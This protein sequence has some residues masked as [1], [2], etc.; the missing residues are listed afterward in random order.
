MNVEIDDNSEN[1]NLSNKNNLDKYDKNII[2]ARGANKSNMPSP[3]KHRSHRKKTYGEEFI[4]NK[5]TPIF[6]VTLLLIGMI[7]FFNM[8]I[9]ESIIKLLFTDT[10]K[11]VSYNTNY[12]FV[13]IPI[14]L[15]GLV[16]G[17]IFVGFSM[18]YR[19]T[20]QL[21]SFA[22]CIIGL[23]T[24]IIN[25]TMM[26]FYKWL[27]NPVH[28][29][30][31]I[32]FITSG[33][34]YFSLLLKNHNIATIAVFGNFL[35]LFF[36]MYE[37]GYGSFMAFLIFELL[38]SIGFA[39][40][41][42]I[43]RWNLINFLNFFFVLLMYI[44]W[45]Y[46][47]VLFTD[48]T[49]NIQ[50]S[51]V[52]STLLFITFLITVLPNFKKGFVKQNNTDIMILFFNILFYAI[53]SF[54]TIRKLEL[55]AFN[56][57]FFGLF[58]I[59]LIYVAIRLFKHP[60][61]AV[62]A[63]YLTFGFSYLLVCLAIFLLLQKNSILIFSSIAIIFSYW[64]F[65]ITQIKIFKQFSFL[66]LWISFISFMYITLFKYINMMMLEESFSI[67]SHE[68][69]FDYT[70]AGIL[71]AISVFLNI[72]FIN[73]EKKKTITLDIPRKKYKTILISFL[74]IILYFTPFVILFYNLPMYIASN[75]FINIILYSFTI[76]FIVV[77]FA[78]IQ[79]HVSKLF[80]KIYLGLII[81]LSLIYPIASN[82]NNINVL[83]EYFF[84]EHASLT[85]FLFHYI[86]VFIII[87]SIIILMKTILNKF[88]YKTLFMDLFWIYGS[89]MLLFIIS[90]ETYYISM[91][92][93]DNK[94][95]LVFEAFT[96][97]VII[98]IF[99]IL[100]S[101][102]SLLFM[103]IGI[104][105]KIRIIRVISLLIFFI[106]IIKLFVYDIAD[107]SDKIKVMM[108]IL[109]GGLLLSFSFLYKKI[110]RTLFEK[111]D[112]E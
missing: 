86:N 87:A 83:L 1:K 112:N 67:L 5:L 78:I 64:F 15:I 26:F 19:K 71:V 32:A 14:R 59:L 109:I 90:S 103:I 31:Y 41:S 17:F 33:I 3:Q 75:D 48:N 92:F 53:F 51:L 46:K 50:L 40:L 18:Y 111:D 81:G 21:L 91:F 12:N 52:F 35:M 36:S 34:I 4:L 68:I 25:L 66:F 45:L 82:T 29:Y 2:F 106:V 105:Y 37:N 58:G 77:S 80:I 74:L 11:N 61:L 49:A 13:G 85:G 43:K 54:F 8:D 108:F 44:K 42:Y 62:I 28:N 27:P 104:M 72:L 20:K 76:F 94:N 7:L 9:R 98:I 57:I 100:W 63:P 22:V 23:M 24:I 47:K 93:V 110:F 69:N 10:N 65:N 89:M 16:V 6:G 55:F 97:N 84:S 30:F 79:K 102:V 56:P 95:H 107:L 60:D 70:I 39:I 88:G 101:L 96:Q 38:I 99:P 73:V